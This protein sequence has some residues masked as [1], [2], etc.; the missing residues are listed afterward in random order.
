VIG[1]ER[2]Y[3]INAQVYLKTFVVGAYF[4]DTNKLKNL[5]VDDLGRADR[6][7]HEIK[8]MRFPQKRIFGGFPMDNVFVGTHVYDRDN[9]PLGDWEA[10]KTQMLTVWSGSFKAIVTENGKEI[11]RSLPLSIGKPRSMLVSNVRRTR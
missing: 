7:V 2:R 9:L 11:V 4:D 10:E 3:A 5:D 8:L 6:G 1:K